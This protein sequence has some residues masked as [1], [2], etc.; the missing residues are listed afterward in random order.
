LLKRNA[1]ERTS[2]VFQKHKV[3]E[4]P[5]GPLASHHQPGSQLN[6]VVRQCG[7]NQKLSSPRCPQARRGDFTATARTSFKPNFPRL[8]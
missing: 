4:R 7:R 3:F 2:L 8:H 1:W 5:C 6:N